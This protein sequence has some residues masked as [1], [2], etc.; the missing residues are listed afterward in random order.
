MPP[1]APIDPLHSPHYALE[2][3]VVTM[4]ATGTVLNR[5]TVYVDAGRIVAVTR[6][7]EP[8]PAGQDDPPVLRT[9]GTIYPGLIE[10]HNHLSYNILPLWRVP[11]RYTN[12]DQWAGTPEYQKRI[13][14][15][16][17]VLGRTK[18]YVEA[19]VRYAECKCLLGGVTTT[20]GLA[21][22]SNAGITRYYRGVVRNV[23]Q[24]DDPELPE[25]A[26]SIADIEAV[27]ATRF[28][29]R[30]QRS[31]CLL[32]HLSEGVD[33]TARRRF[34]ALRLADGTW[35][36]APALA[37]IHSV[38]LTPAD[39]AILRD[40]GVSVVWSPFSNLLLYG[41]TLD[42]AAAKASGV[43]LG[44]GSDWALSGSKNLLGELKVAR[45]VSAAAGGVF[46]DRE[47]VAMATR[48][49]AAILRWDRALGSIESGKRADLLVLAGRQGDPY[50]ALLE[51]RETAITGVII[52][53][54]PRYGSP[55]LM[56]RFGPGTER[57]RVGG[58]ARVLNL[59]HEGGADLVG[60]LSLRAAASRLRGG[61]RRLAALARV[62]EE[63]GT[64]SLDLEPEWSLV[65]EEEEPPGMVLRPYLA[66]GE[67][68]LAEARDLFADASRGLGAP[69][70]QILEPLPLDPLVVANDPRFLPGL[71]AQPNLP[72]FVK[73]GLP[74]LY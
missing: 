70:S 64:R 49:A 1:P 22:F 62:L 61:L 9:G 27:D 47:L 10:L 74:A 28:L 68:T 17:K 72:D 13:S 58:A 51:A 54:V 12:R 65:L 19:I 35:A 14:G 67:D 32:L 24:T 33:A 71:A 50:A 41:G 38:A 44:L 7:G 16:L 30:L 52:N 43:R 8:P 34:E 21:L 45:L 20:Q 53:G 29:A 5:G 4:D 48:D 25:A 11:R 15:P 59:A 73:T 40:H 37:G 26:T 63:D 60:A 55:R 56:E 66:G 42:I 46:S 23:E 31:S 57:V 2:G 39:F 18:G 3:R 69:L 6:A 36:L